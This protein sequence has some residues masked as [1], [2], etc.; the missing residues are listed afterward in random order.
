MVLACHSFNRTFM[1]LKFYKA[2]Y[3]TFAPKRFN[4]TFMELK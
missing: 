2:W 3:D 1:E 4:R